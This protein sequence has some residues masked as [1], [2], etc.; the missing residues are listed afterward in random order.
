[1]AELWGMHDGLQSAWSLR[2]KKVILQT[3]SKEALQAFK[4]WT[5]SITGLRLPAPF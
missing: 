2:E 4:V 3:D 1:M 5:R